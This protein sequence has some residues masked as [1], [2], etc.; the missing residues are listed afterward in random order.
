MSAEVRAGADAFLRLLQ[1]VNLQ[2][3]ADFAAEDDGALDDVDLRNYPALVALVDASVRENFVDSS[4]QRRQGFLRAIADLLAMHA[5]GAV[6]GAGW[7]PLKSSEAAFMA[8][9]AARAAIRHAE[10]R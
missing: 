8:P 9:Q 10:Q 5:D 7:D 6:P 3:A 2:T 4:P 1:Q